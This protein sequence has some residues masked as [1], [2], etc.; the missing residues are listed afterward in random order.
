MGQIKPA[1]GLLQAC[2]Q[3]QQGQLRAD[4]YLEQCA[5]R[6]DES[7]SELKAFTVRA[8][9]KTLCQESKPGPLMGIP[10]AVKDIVATKDF[11]T[12]MGSPIYKDFLPSEDAE[13]VRKIRNLGGVIFGKTVTTEFAWRH[14]GATT[15]PWN[16]SHTPGGSSSGSA[17]AV[18]CGIVPL[19]LGS[20]TAGSIIRPASYCGVVGYKASFGAVP[21]TGVHPVSD[22]L[23][24]IGFF[25]RSVADAR[26]AFNLLRNT[27]ANEKDAIVIPELLPK[28]LSD[29]LGSQKPCIALLKTPFDDLLSQEQIETVKYAASLLERT[30]A[31]IEEIGLPQIYWDG[32][33]ALAVLMACEAAVVHEKHLEQFPELLGLDIKELIEKGRSYSAD[34]YTQ[35]KTLQANLRLSIAQYFEN[36]D[37]I[38]TAPATGEAP[39]GLSFTG[40]PIFCSLWTL[41]GTPA[42]ALPV[43][44]SSNGLPLGIQL[45]GNY[46]EDE[47]LLNIA[48]FAEKCL[49]A[50]QQ[51]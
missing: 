15:N 4:D 17:A 11:V 47:K 13:I 5:I 25:T 45:I 43:H 32:I 27:E 6:A 1:I 16:S 21:R 46:K 29:M 8:S 36:F 33:G 28:P 14:A 50:E 26:Y 44:Q 23:D 3:I 48:E 41:I 24:H 9:L 38:L 12:T 10:I 40:N 37:A 39:K 31:H 34:D 42:I 2:A 51:K 7:E 49:L 30:G 19:S 18:A 22:S 35:A 20:Q